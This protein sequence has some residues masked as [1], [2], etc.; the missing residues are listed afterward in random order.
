MN[1]SRT[2][3][4]SRQVL[5]FFRWSNLQKTKNIIAVNAKTTPLIYAFCVY[6]VIILSF[7]LG[8]SE[9][10]RLPL[11]GQMHVRNV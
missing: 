10:L 5:E 3:E 8:T 9:A 6:L 2:N 7:L 4:G 11:A 1:R